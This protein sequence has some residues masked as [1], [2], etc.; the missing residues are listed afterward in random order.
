VKIFEL[1]LRVYN[2]FESA[3][4]ANIKLAQILKELLQEKIKINLTL[5]ESKISGETKK[6]LQI[7]N[8][9]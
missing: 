2:W 8:E 4:G 6:I 5:G 9:F 3:M 1:A 7:L